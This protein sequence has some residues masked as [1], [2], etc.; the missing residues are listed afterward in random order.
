MGWN[1]IFWYTEGMKTTKI[2]LGTI[3]LVIIIFGAYNFFVLG[4]KDFGLFTEYHQCENG[5][6]YTYP[7]G[8]VDGNWTYYD[9]ENK[10]LATCSSFNPDEAIETRCRDISEM[11]AQCN[12]KG[13]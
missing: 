3:V 11:A 8:I 12:K 4:L 6:H 10:K 13:L 7:R 1:G 5:I 2:I 9:L